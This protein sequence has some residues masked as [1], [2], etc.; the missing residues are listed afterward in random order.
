[1]TRIAGNQP[2]E[3]NKKLAFLSM[4]AMRKN[5]IFVFFLLYA[6]GAYQLGEMED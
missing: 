4:V 2:K 1:M 5:M 6:Y 3:L